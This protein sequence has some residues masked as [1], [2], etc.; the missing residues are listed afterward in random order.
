[1][2]SAAPEA[3]RLSGVGLDVVR[4]SPAGQPGA[5]LTALA[6]LACFALLYRLFDRLYLRGWRGNP[7]LRDVRSL[8]S[9]HRAPAGPA[10]TPLTKLVLP[11]DC[12]IED[13]ASPSIDPAA[14]PKSRTP[15]LVFVNKGSGGKIGPLLLEC[16]SDLLNP[17]QVWELGSGDKNPEGALR[18]FRNVPGLRVLACGGDGTISWVAEAMRAADLAPDA[19]LCPVPLGTGNDYC[20]AL[21]WG[22]GF[23]GDRS[24][25]AQLL[26]RIAEGYVSYTDRWQV[27]QVEPPPLR[28]AMVGRRPHT[29]ELRVGAEQVAAAGDDGLQLRY[30]FT[31]K[32]YDV[33]FSVSFAPADGHEERVHLVELSRHQSHRAPVRGTV[34]V[35]GAGTLTLSFDNSYSR[36]RRKQVSFR[37]WL[38]P[39]TAQPGLS[40]T[41]LTATAAVQTK[42]DAREAGNGEGVK[43][44]VMNNYLGVGADAEVTL[45]FH[46]MRTNHPWLFTSRLL[47]KL[48]YLYIGASCTLR[49]Y[50][51]PA[52][53]RPLADRLRLFADGKP[54]PIPAGLRG[55]I[56]LNLPSFGG[57]LDMW[58]TPDTEAGTRK[59]KGQ[60]WA[61]Q[62]VNDGLLEVVGVESSFDI[63]LQGGLG[64]MGVQIAQRLAQASTLRLELDGGDGSDRVRDCVAVQCDG[65]PWLARPGAVIALGAAGQTAVM[66]PREHIGHDVVKITQTVIAEAAGDGIIDEGQRAAIAGRL[67][68]RLPG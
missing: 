45:R 54:V 6:T 62:S 20:Q 58:A 49:G 53:E 21:G 39:A 5:V 18:L 41:A 44:L 16:F 22:A 56:V 64:A 8:R 34:P 61:S 14:L 60:V 46:Q 52:G 13:S 11:P 33:G 19:V 23:D 4:F 40:S 26:A 35:P 3:A 15:A 10:L 12:A 17:L 27:A 1:M 43:R 2:A 67:A 59:A 66:R 38:E 63:G 57:G 25:V 55:V 47:N 36:L 30:T 9:R 29:E 51:S 50:F 65:E 48:I 68:A 28:T 24:S 42:K 7:N 32:G 31:T 37:A